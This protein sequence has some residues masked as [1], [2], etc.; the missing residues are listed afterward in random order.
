MDLLLLA[1]GIQEEI[2]G[3][4][5]VEQGDDPVTERQLRRIVAAADWGKRRRI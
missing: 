1:P 2:L 4:P 5:V 3:L